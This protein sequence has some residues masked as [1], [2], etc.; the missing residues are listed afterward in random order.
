MKACRRDLEATLGLEEKALDVHKTLIEQ[1]VLSVGLSC[2]P[3]T[4]AVD[5]T[6]CTAGRRHK[7]TATQL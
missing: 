6:T 3:A 7:G 1:R 2:M 4:S 5:H